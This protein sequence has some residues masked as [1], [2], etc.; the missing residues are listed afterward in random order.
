MVEE[1]SKM[2]ARNYTDLATPEFHQ[3]ELQLEQQQQADYADEP[4]NNSYQQMQQEHLKR[5]MSI[6]GCKATRK[7]LRPI[8]KPADVERPFNR[9][10]NLNSSSRTR[11]AG[12]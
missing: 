3:H 9:S 10:L 4:P 2:Q 5:V 1:A 12:Q 6:Y 7:V 8:R 11:F